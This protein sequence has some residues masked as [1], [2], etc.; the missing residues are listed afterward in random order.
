MHLR[1]NNHRTLYAIIG[2]FLLPIVLAHVL[3]HTGYGKQHH[4]TRGTLLSPPVTIQTHTQSYWQI[5]SLIDPNKQ[6][7]KYQTI[8]KRRLALGQDAKRVHL[9]FI[10]NQTPSKPEDTA[11]ETLIVDDNTLA[12]LQAIKSKQAHPCI[13]FIVNPNSRAIMC[14]DESNDL[15]DIDFDLRKLLKLSQV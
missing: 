11:W 6:A 1:K 9:S 13:L 7:Q 8:E 2:V 12:T 3:F 10:A 4:R 5:A 15:K 14:Y